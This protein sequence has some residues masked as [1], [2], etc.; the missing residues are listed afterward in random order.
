M[1][2]LGVRP[3]SLGDPKSAAAEDGALREEEK[4]ALYCDHRK[5]LGGQFGDRACS[6]A[7]THLGKSYKIQH[8]AGKV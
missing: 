1:T 5:E 4:V 7:L 6:A 3:Q 2:S 8:L